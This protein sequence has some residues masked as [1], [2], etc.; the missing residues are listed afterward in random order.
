[1]QGQTKSQSE[2]VR[3][4]RLVREAPRN[5]EI[6]TAPC[7]SNVAHL[8]SGVANIPHQA[9]NCND[10]AGPDHHHREQSART[11]G[12]P[13]RRSASCRRLRHAPSIR[14]RLPH[15]QPCIATQIAILFPF[16]GEVADGLPLA[17]DSGANDGRIRRSASTCY[18]CAAVTVKSAQPSWAT[19]PS[20][21]S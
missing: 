13:R 14:G 20:R 6:L 2:R 7:A 5:D 8:A 16:E 19:L 1:M 17:W 4:E 21:A 10:H 11:G 18:C 15:C 12:N 9:N 3:R